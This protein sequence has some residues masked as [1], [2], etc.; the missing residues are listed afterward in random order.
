MSLVSIQLNT[1]RGYAGVTEFNFSPI[2]DS[3]IIV[4]DVL[5]NFGDG[6][7]SNILEPSHTYKVPGQYTSTL[8]VYASSGQ[9][10]SNYAN[11]D[12]SLYVNE[13]V[14][15]NFVPPP[16]FAGHLNR[17]P[18]RVHITSRT[19]DE[20]FI[21]LG[22]QFSRSYQYQDLNTKWSFLR[23][24]WRFLDL[25]GNVI[26]SIKTKDTPIRIDNNGKI[27]PN[28]KVAGV[29]GVAEFY[30]VDDIYNFDL[31]ATRQP[32]TTLIATLQ[33]SA[34]RAYQDG[35]NIDLTMPGFSNS[36]A[37][38]TTPYVTLLRI[39]SQLKI[40]ENGLRPYSNPR[41]NG[42]SNPIIINS[43]FG[44]LPYYDDWFDGNLMSFALPEQFFVKTFPISNEYIPKIN[45]GVIGLSSYF[46]PT[47]EFTWTD[48]SGYK[49]PGYYKGNFETAKV[50]TRNTCLT[51]STVIT[52]PS[53]T[54][55]YFNPILWVSNPNAGVMST[56]QYKYQDNL[57]PAITENLKIAQIYTFEVP[58]IHDTDF[59]TNSM[60]VSGFHGID[61][62]AALP[63]PNYHA[64]GADAENNHLYRFST[65]GELLCAVDLNKIVKDNNLGFLVKNQVSPAAIALDGLRNIWVTLHDSVSTL[66]L[67]PAG[68]FLFAVN[69]LSSTGYAFPPKISPIWYEQNTSFQ[70][71]YSG[72]IY[73]NILNAVDLN[74]VEPTGLDTDSKN[75]VW[76]SYSYFASGYLVKYGPEGNLI[77]TITYPT[78][79]CPQEI[80][81]D[82]KDNVWI[83]LSDNIHKGPSY[84]Q[85]L[86]SN[87]VLLSTFGPFRG[88]NHL[89]IDTSQ[90]IWFTHS[91]NWI[92][93][94]DTN[95]AEIFTAQLSGNGVT[96]NIPDWWDPSVNTD[97]TALEGISC[98]I[99]GY[100]YVINSVENQIYVVDGFSKQLVNRFFVNP[101]GYDYY[102][103]KD[104]DPTEIAYNI[105][106][107]S[108]QASGDWSGWRWINKYGV[109]YLPF[110]NIYASNIYLS[111]E[112]RKLDFYNE[113][114][115]Y[116][117]K[118]NENHDLADQMKSVAFQPILAN[119]DNIFDN[120]LGSIF[121]KYPYK[122]NDLGVASYEKIANFVSNTTDIDYCNVT[123]LYGASSMLD[124]EFDNFKLSY[125]PLIER[126][127]DLGSIN[128]S[129]LWGSR[130][131][132]Q[133]NFMI[134]HNG[135]INRGDLITSTNYT[136]SAG[137][138]VILKIKSINGY[139][140]INTGLIDNQ[141]TYTLNT[142]ALF[143]NLDP[144]IWTQYYEFYEFKPGFD[145]TQTEGLIDWDN[146]S[147]TLHQ[148]ASSAENWMGSEGVLETLIAKELYNGLKLIK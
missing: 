41:W 22:A 141:T 25:D 148:Y 87:G 48:S 17:Y 110:Y 147:T 18:F 81:V 6:N 1:N 26:T 27:D 20:H 113:D 134:Q 107:K 11:I 58:L 69:P 108:A 129:R 50:D 77:T 95:T 29:S 16:T 55:S 39:P 46:H 91:Y 103:K 119:S 125:P 88:L 7:T 32:Y 33:T 122:V 10:Y 144:D 43:N 68:N 98:D 130:Q 86:N 99:R 146:P 111:G 78:C 136:V 42:V 57:Y 14:Y 47:V 93:N 106:N 3:S 35:F 131:L 89:N 13:S 102:I 127:M 79:A 31:A 139:K 143:L 61:C 104:N 59:E 92:G 53:L 36:L 128:Q 74:F 115:N 62:I 54:A 132:S 117:F 24:H 97:E 9:I 12:I 23:P 73:D 64:W 65:K 49:T 70:D 137:T 140:L 138:P 124:L 51:A 63:F 72:D 19:T 133:N 15:F 100:V 75:N 94:V 118:K 56:V 21:D 28:G 38:A 67:D 101:Q 80:V 44:G 30:F 109:K 2:V 114:P 60:T 121:G 34:I 82:V 66:K 120:F 142:L 145:N 40:S 8:Q 5:W 76:T 71:S 85:K 90:N 83:A 84:L 112:S 105:W 4:T 96:A 116:I 37:T 135:I 123:E 126:L 45:V 52:I